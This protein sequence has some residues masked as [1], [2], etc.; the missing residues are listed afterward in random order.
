MIYFIVVINII[1]ILF[2]LIFKDQ[3]KGMEGGY[4]KGVWAESSIYMIQ[5]RE[6]LFKAKVMIVVSIAL[7]VLYYYK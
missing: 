4:G 1:A 5:A 7:D 3:V 6:M 2:Y